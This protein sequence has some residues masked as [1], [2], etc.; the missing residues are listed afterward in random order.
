MKIWLRSHTYE[1]C[2]WVAVWDNLRKAFIE[3]GDDVVAYG[4]PEDPEEY[5]ELWWGD[6][7][8]WQWSRYDVRARIAYTL[9][10]AH[11]IIKSG[12]ERAIAN[13]N[14]GDVV[15][16]TAQ[17]AAIAFLE[18]PIDKP[19]KVVFLG[20][21]PEQFQY[22]ERS[23]ESPVKFLH[24]GVSQ[25]R[26]GSW[27]VPEAFIKAFGNEVGVE[28]TI[29]SPNLSDMFVQ[30]SAEYSQHRNISFN[31]EYDKSIFETYAEHHIYVSPHIAEGFG[32]MIPESMCT[33][34]PA[35]VARCS[36]PREYFCKEHGWW[37]EMSENYLPV[38]DCL[39]D[40]AGFW[41]VPSVDSLA[42]VMH[43]AYSDLEICEQKG[44]AGSQY[45]RDTL[46]WQHTV[47]ALKNIIQEVLDAKNLSSSTGI[48]RREVDRSNAIQCVP[49]R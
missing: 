32:L 19:I 36:A 40:T 17:C 20:A 47:K 26:K 21:N 29:S 45:I 41:R 46:T 37:V 23:W 3:N 11:S 7:Q 43:D 39:V 10:E 2:S 30:L 38:S 15:I 48:Q 34:M 28:L 22:V 27:L 14:R 8:F 18:A 9:S 12:R 24:A 33:G 13:L 5:V 6:A 35:I 25:I 4:E 1:P 16:A 42:S 44:R 49:T 31:G